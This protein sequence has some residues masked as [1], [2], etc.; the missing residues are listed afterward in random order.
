MNKHT[1][2]V[3]AAALVAVCSCQKSEA[4]AP[5]DYAS[6][7]VFVL[8]FRDAA[9]GLAQR[10]IGLDN[11]ARAEK[12]GS[13]DVKSRIS[14]GGGFAGFFLWDTAF[15]AIWASRLPKGTF[16][17]ADSLDNF[18]RFA[19]PEGFINREFTSEGE[20]VW[21][22]RHPNSFAPPLLAWA[23]RELFEQG[24]TDL[25]RLKRVYPAL[26][27]H[28]ACCRRFRR[29]DGLYFGDTLGT[30]MDEL[31][32]WPVGK[33]VEDCIEGG[34]P[35]SREMIGPSSQWM[36]ERPWM[37]ASLAFR[38]WN[39]QAGW[40]DMTAQM[41]FDAKNL[42]FLARTL[43]KADE[44]ARFEAEQREIGEAINRLC[45][46]EKTGFY[47]D[48]G[49]DGLILRR[50]IGAAWT[51]LAGIVPKDRLARVVATLV[52]PELF[53][54]PCGVPALPK[55]DPDYRPETGYWCGV[56]WPP[57][58]Y[59]T[60]RGLRENGYEREAEDLARRWYNA[61]AALWEVS[62]TIWENISPEQ[63]DHPKGSSNPDFCGWAALAPVAL[64]KDFGW[65]KER[66]K[67]K[68]F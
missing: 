30:G 38:Q 33:K 26:V 31:P 9:C 56:V 52:D 4:A 19:T 40:I 23:E 61:Y 54:R 24:H 49:P 15:G 3:V 65:L 7:A 55:G 43:G 58:T 57:T 1:L 64:P 62:G 46:D 28:H 39:R 16:P 29:A 14:T 36:W 50:H 60:I 18:Y 45:W 10:K 59:M 35:F 34:I 47:Y 8:R 27:R 2:T 5:R 21:S 68:E 44:A 13:A 42:A 25:A 20:P 66:N 67:I 17:A 32:R 53:G 48:L 6:D 63:C 12:G 51:L 37:K 22:D 11:L 41:A